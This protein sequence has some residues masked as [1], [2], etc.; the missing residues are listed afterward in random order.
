MAEEIRDILHQHAAVCAGTHRPYV[1]SRRCL[2]KAVRM[3]G[4]EITYE[5][6]IDRYSV[7]CERLRLT[8]TYDPVEKRTY[9]LDWAKE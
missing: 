5:P 4:V 6:H 3:H 7:I 9:V 1:L 2:R 8:S